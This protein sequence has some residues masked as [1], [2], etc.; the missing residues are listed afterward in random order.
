MKRAKVIERSL[1][2]GD[3]NYHIVIHSAEEGG[4]WAEVVELPGCYTQGETVEET[5]EHAEEAIEC[6]LEAME[7]DRIVEQRDLHAQRQEA[8]ENLARIR[9]SQPP[10]V[11][12]VN[13]GVTLLRED[14]ER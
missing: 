1:T 14:R 11:P 7:E 8:L 5:M 9:R 2:V 6:F 12:G 13:D 4:F 10:S 3:T